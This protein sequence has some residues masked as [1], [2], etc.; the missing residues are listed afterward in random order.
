MAKMCSLVIHVWEAEELRVGEGSTCRGERGGET[1]MVLCWYSY[2]GGVHVWYAY[3]GGMRI[4][5]EAVLPCK[6]S[7]VCMCWL[8][9]RAICV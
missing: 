4:W 3:G 2:G 5:E 7:S 1:D 9:R 6:T 8:K